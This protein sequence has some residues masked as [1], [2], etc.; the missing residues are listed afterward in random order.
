MVAVGIMAHASRADQ[1]GALIEQLGGV[2]AVEVSMDIAPAS[3]DP[4]QRWVTGAGAWRAAAAR[5]ANWTLV[6]QDDA[7]LCEDFLDGFAA[8]LRHLEGPAVVSPYMGRGR[9]AS[10]TVHR[11]TSVA[12]RRRETWIE[13]QALYWG[14]AIA[15]P[16][17]VVPEMLA[18]C[19]P[20][21]RDNYDA[22]IARFVLH[23]LRWRAMYTWPSLVQHRD[24]PSLVSHSQ[25]GRVAARFLEE[26]ALHV[27][28]SRLP[29]SARGAIR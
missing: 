13:L 2:E 16:T 29:N 20:L 25:P 7:V 28:W 17:R 22:R 27:D 8:A 10:T 23:R 15:L 5:G 19:G 6:L 4:Q 12:D 14:V 11:A 3:R 1:L 18:W 9:P 26:S 21:R 24:G